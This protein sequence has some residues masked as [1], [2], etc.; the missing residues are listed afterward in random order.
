MDVLGIKIL[1]HWL[2]RMDTLKYGSGLERMDVLG[3]I[4]LVIG[5]LPM[6]TIRWQNG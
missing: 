3:M 1:V 5:L 6:D 2:L 4:V